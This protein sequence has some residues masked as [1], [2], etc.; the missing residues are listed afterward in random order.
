MNKILAFLNIKFLVSEDSFK[1]WRLILFVSF[2]A[3]LMIFSV[4]SAENKI[5]KIALLNE[6][7]NQLKSQF[8]ESRAYLMELKMESKVIYKLRDTDIRPADKP[9]IKLILKN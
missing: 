5:F 3:L 1:N 8:V 6:Q 9:P 7:I 4:H 2:L